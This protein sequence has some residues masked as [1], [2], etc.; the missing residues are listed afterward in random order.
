[1]RDN[2]KDKLKLIQ[3]IAQ[4]LPTRKGP[5]IPGLASRRG[6][7]ISGGLSPTKRPGNTVAPAVPAPKQSTPVQSSTP[8]ATTFKKIPEV[9]TMQ[10]SMQSL[11]DVVMRDATSD[12]MPLRS[13][14]T[15]AHP[16]DDA[17]KSAKKAFVDFIAEQYAGTLDAD[18]RGVEWTTD[19]S[20]STVPGKQKTQTGIYELNVV[21][22]TLKRIGTGSKEF[23]ADGDWKE[24]TQNALKNIM[25]FGHALLQLESDFGIENKIY[26]LG[27]WNNFSNLL[28]S[29]KKDGD[30]SQLAT[31]VTKHVQ[32]IK[33]LYIE[34]SNQVLKLPRLR[35]LLEGKGSFDKYDPSGT[36][37]D[38]LSKEEEG[39]VAD[40][41]EVP[42]TL[43]AP[44]KEGQ[45]PGRIDRLP[46]SVLKDKDSFD[47]FIRHYGWDP[48]TNIASKLLQAIKKQ[49][50]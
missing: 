7:G 8:R 3:K 30:N 20:V 27:D 31:E 26:E 42:V 23:V 1:M 45:L 21:M 5:G 13:E 19:K 36:T 44:A 43:M 17:T 15:I 33:N 11:A 22:D 32:A 50:G 6:P 37:K 14:D 35:P 9:K 41:A 25:G 4:D 48:T 24:R 18:K 49:L 10:E 16:A 28:D 12:T 40:K 38:I 29:Y 34:F 46:L 39:L 2:L 47:E